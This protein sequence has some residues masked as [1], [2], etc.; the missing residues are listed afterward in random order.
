[1]KANIFS[2]FKSL[3]DSFEKK[4]L[5]HLFGFFQHFFLK[6]KSKGYFSKENPKDIFSKENPK[7]IF[8]KENPKKT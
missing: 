7:D 8:S 2:H 6:G 3:K 1:M 4:A 5:K